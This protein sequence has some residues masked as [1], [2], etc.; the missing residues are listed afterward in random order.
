MLIESPNATANHVNVGWDNLGVILWHNVSALLESLGSLVFP[1]LLHGILAK[2]ILQPLG[3]AAIL[4]CV[5]MARA[6]YAG[7][8]TFFAAAYVALL[9]IWPFQPNQR[10][11]LPIAPVV[12]AGFCFEMMHLARLFRGAFGHRDRSQRVVAYGFAAV[13]A[14]ILAAGLGLQGYMGLSILPEMA[15]ND[16]ADARTYANLYRWIRDHLPA[17]A[18]IVWENDT[19]LYLNSGR[20]ATNFVVPP[21]DY[22]ASEEDAGTTGRYGSIHEFARQHGLG[23]FALAK[24]GLQRNADVLRA[25]A[26]NPNLEHIYEDSGAILYRVR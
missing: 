21:R 20:R 14:V 22:Y 19:A 26:S 4:G 3:V 17:D 8:Y 11:I 2:L 16:R 13:L 25:V 9:L 5:R 15:R 23:Y 24:I 10:Y 12:M 18:A 1:Q 7:M 6:G